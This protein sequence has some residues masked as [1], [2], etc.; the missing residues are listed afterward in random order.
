LPELAADVVPN[1]VL[2]GIDNFLE[3]GRVLLVARYIVG[4]AGRTIRLIAE[5]E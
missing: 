4:L 1:A 5:V 2:V 3:A